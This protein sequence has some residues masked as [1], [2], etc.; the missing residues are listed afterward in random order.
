MQKIKYRAA[1]SLTEAIN[2]I[3]HVMGLKTIA[4]FVENDAILQKITELG[5]DYAQGYGIAEPYPFVLTTDS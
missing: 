3:G 4:E 2:Q 1:T 5:V